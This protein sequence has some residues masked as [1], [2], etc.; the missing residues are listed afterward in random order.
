[1]HLLGLCFSL[2]PSLPYSRMLANCAAY[3]LDIPMQNS[4]LCTVWKRRRGGLW[5]I[6]TLFAVVLAN[7]WIADEIYPFVH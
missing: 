7:Y 2:F 5:L 4:S 6:G 3:M 1:M